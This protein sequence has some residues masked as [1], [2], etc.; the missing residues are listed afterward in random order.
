M[1]PLLLSTFDTVGGA[2]RASYRLQKGLNQIGT[3]AGML[4]QEKW[5]D[6]CTVIGPATAA[7]FL[8]GK[9]RSALNPLPAILYPRRQKSLFSLPL[10]P[11]SLPKRINRIDHDILHLHWVSYGFIPISAIKAF[12]KPLIW[13][14]HDMWPLTGGCH[15]SGMCNRY[16]EMCGSCPILGSSSHFDL[17]RWVMR[18]KMREWDGV[19]LTIVTPSHWMATCAQRSRLFRSARVVTIPN[20]LDI[21]RYRPMDK[22]LA[23]MFLS[24]PPEKKLVLF[25]AI[26]STT[27]QRKGFQLLKEAISQLVERG[28]VND[29]ELV[30]FGASRPASPLEL[31]MKIHYVGTLHDDVSLALLYGAADVYVLPSLQDNLPN[32]VMEALACGTPCVAFRIGGLPDMIEHKVNGYLAVPYEPADLA[33]GIAWVMRDHEQ[34]QVLSGN[35]RN[36][37]EREFAL[38][39]VAMR[40][41]E[42]YAEVI[43]T[44]GNR[45]AGM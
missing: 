16:E 5:S 26:A 34:W 29:V 10:L 22:K 13:T 11:S 38:C 28:A 39:K 33:A 6:D 14:L 30:V 12:R 32:T 2:A 19:A 23:R 15:Y 44:S 41:T 42:L 1:K 27:E 7:E 21:E 36:K 35:A 45:Q 40:Y 3:E 17:S 43:E 8:L 24:L 18:R 31:G 20:G 9:L 37:V 25:G 4:V